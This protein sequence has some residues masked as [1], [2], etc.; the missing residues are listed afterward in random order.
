MIEN[1][2]MSS[3]SS[4]E[5]PGEG[6]IPV[7][8]IL[9][10][11]ESVALACTWLAYLTAAAV[12]AWAVRKLIADREALPVIIVLAAA[13][14]SNI[15]PI[16]DQ[17]GLINWAANWPWFEYTML[18]RKI[19]AMVVVGLVGYYAWAYYLADRLREGVSI[20]RM[21]LLSLIGGIPEIVAE[22]VIHQA[23]GI[24]YY[25]DNPSRLLGIPIYTIIQNS[26]LFPVVA[27]VIYLFA[28]YVRG[29]R[30]L[31]LV[32]AMPGIVLGYVFG[33][34]W[35]VYQAVGSSAPGWVVL[36]TAA[37]AVAASIGASYVALQLPELRMRRESAA[38]TPQVADE[39]VG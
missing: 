30:Q 31:W 11:N 22:M 33:T 12:L 18:G 23:G 27:V 2:K 21:Y 37:W 16:G 28:T 25:G 19:P 8:P 9:H 36:I 6:Q 26:T 4:V 38:L 32:I 24:A 3:G 10:V 13:V 29:L 7:A 34:T 1:L 14:T 17:V 39:V 35:P 20:R 15:E 5:L